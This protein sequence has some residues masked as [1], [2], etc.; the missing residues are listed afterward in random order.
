MKHFAKGVDISTHNGIVN[1]EELKKAGIEFVI[2][3]CGYGGDSKNQDDVMFK[4]NVEQCKKHNI[5]YGVY[6]Y[7]YAKSVEGAKSEAEHMLRLL[8]GSKPVYGCWYDVEDS[9]LPD[10]RKALTDQVVTFCEALEKQGLYVGI[11]SS[12]SWFR[13]RFDNRIDDYDKW[14]AQW[15]SECTYSEPYGIWQFTSSLNIG[16]KLFDGNY[17]YKDYPSLMGF[18]KN[19]TPK[20]SVDEIAIEVISGSWG[21]GSERSEKLTKAGYNPSEVQKRVNEYYK[22]ASE[23]VKGTYGNGAV[24]KSKLKKLGFDYETVQAIVNVIL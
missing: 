12:L 9:S 24:R 1:F 13:T 20:K 21:D 23:C 17:S 3:R 8:N 2:I 6:L 10:N 11:Y 7:S 22:I 4:R 16:G 15:N 5:P 14:V 18:N 19:P